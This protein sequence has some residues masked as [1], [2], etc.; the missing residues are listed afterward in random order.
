MWI[1][2][3]IQRK[4]CGRLFFCLRTQMNTKRLTTCAVIAAA[5]AALSILLAPISYGPVQVRL[6]EAMTVLPFVAPYTA[7]GLFVGCLLANLLN[8]LGV[9]PLDVVLGSLA[10]LLAAIMT[11]RMK[12]PLA[13][14]IPPVLVNAIVIGAV[15]AFT[16]AP[17]AFWQSF[18]L[19]AAEIG[20]GQLLSCTLGGLLLLKLLER[21]GLSS[22]LRDK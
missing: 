12:R 3:R 9:N 8:P 15:L 11:A 6:S 19:F 5:Y 13:A 21:T 14:T 1:I 10:T 22:R 4:E 18:G 16:T 20:V 2:E 17:G 7:G